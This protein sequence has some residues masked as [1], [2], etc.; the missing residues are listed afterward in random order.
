MADRRHNALAVVFVAEGEEIRRPRRVF[1][2]IFAPAPHEQDDLLRRLFRSAAHGTEAVGGVV[3]IPARVGVRREELRGVELRVHDGLAQIGEVKRRRGVIGDDERTLAKDAVVVALLPFRPFHLRR[4]GK[5]GVRPAH[6]R[7][8]EKLQLVAEPLGGAEQT[9]VAKQLGIESEIVRLR[10]GGVPEHAVAPPG[11]HECDHPPARALVAQQI[12]PRKPREHHLV[13]QRVAL[14][15]ADGC[16]LARRARHEQVGAHG[17]LSVHRGDV[18]FGHAV[19]QKRKAHLCPQVAKFGHRKGARAAVRLRGGAHLR[20][21]VQQQVF[22]RETGHDLP[23]LLQA[24]IVGGVPVQHE[25]HLS[26]I[27]GM[28]VEIVKERLAVVSRRVVAVGEEPDTAHEGARDAVKGAQSGAEQPPPAPAAKRRLEARFGR[29]MAQKA[30]AADTEGAASEI[31]E[32]VPHR[33]VTAANS[34]ERKELFKGKGGKRQLF[35]LFFIE[36]AHK[37]ALF[38]QGQEKAHAHALPDDA[39]VEGAFPPRRRALA[40]HEALARVREHRGR[41]LGAHRQLEH[42]LVVPLV[43]ILRRRLGRG[44]RAARAKKPHLARAGREEFELFD[45]ARLEQPERAGELF[46]IRGKGGAEHRTRALG[47]AHHV[48]D[49]VLRKRVLQKQRAFSVQAHSLFVQRK[50]DRIEIGLVPGR[51][52]L[53]EADQRIVAPL[54]AAVVVPPARDHAEFAAGKEQA[55]DGEKVLAAGGRGVEDDLLRRREAEKGRVDE[56][57][58]RER[59]LVRKDGARAARELLVLPVRPARRAEKADGHRGDVHVRIAQKIPLGGAERPAREAVVRVHEIDDALGV[60]QTEIARARHPAVGLVQG[61]H[62]GIAAGVRVAQRARAV[63]G[64]VVHEHQLYV[65]KADALAAKAVHRLREVFFHVVDRHNDGEPLHLLSPHKNFLKKRRSRPPRG[66]S[67]APALSKRAL[68]A[69][70]ARSGM[71]GRGMRRVAP[72]FRR[73]PTPSRAASAS[74]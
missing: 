56:H 50:G 41:R 30:P 17:V 52:F 71:R 44:R 65:G 21:Q 66:N 25:I 28:R 36:K 13:A 60:L 38:R 9:L 64:A 15:R 43:Q 74:K 22:Y 58:R 29:Q 45:D 26:A 3:E 39:A 51:L 35:P 18:V 4:E 27:C 8:P 61:D 19:L 59:L 11:G 32:A 55:G 40:G 62:V 1:F 70:R 33:A 47:G 53:R 42:E 23:L 12:V 68:C 2:G 72:L 73:R 10:V 31:D 48:P 24:G 49:E 46:G 69:M 54:A 67:F 16:A 7:V 57:K 5:Q 34:G 63:G 14:A 37:D 6:K 20:K